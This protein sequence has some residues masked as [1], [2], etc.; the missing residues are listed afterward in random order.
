MKPREVT[1]KRKKLVTDEEK[2]EQLQEFRRYMSGARAV[3]EQVS[4]H[5]MMEA[6]TR[7]GD[8]MKEKFTSYVPLRNHTFDYEKINVMRQYSKTTPED[9]LTK[10]NL[11]LGGEG[12]T[13]ERFEK[14]PERDTSS[15][16]KERDEVLN[17]DLE[18]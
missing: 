7:I 11:Y 5:E 14:I 15:V 16:T 3:T 17:D 10:Y 1:T 4:R 9:L 12:Q 8:F 6:E 18:M 2:D 13:E